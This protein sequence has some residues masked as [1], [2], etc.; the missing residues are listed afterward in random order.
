MLKDKKGFTLI[1][2][3]AT[4]VLLGIIVGLSIIGVNISIENTK[5]K[6]EDVFVKTLTDAFSI[7]I[8]SDGR[9]LTYNSQVCTIDKSHNTGIKIYKASEQLTLNSIINSSYVP[10]VDS[11]IIN[12]ANEKVTCNKEAAVEIYR[13]EDYVYYYKMNKNDLACLKEE[14]YITNLPS[15]CY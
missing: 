3:L 5:K 4:I 14:G 7:Y 9:R 1:E 6:T 11:D 2:L 15:E 12:P 10:L 8:D 13:D